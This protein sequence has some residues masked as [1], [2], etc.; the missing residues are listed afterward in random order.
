[1]TLYVSHT[2]LY[3]ADG[4]PYTGTISRL[5]GPDFAREDIVSGLPVSVQEH[6]TNGIAFDAQGRL[7]IAQ[8]GTTNAGVASNRHTR[9]ETPLS[10]AVLLAD[11]TDPSFDGAVTYLPP[12]QVT[13]AVRQISG[14]V[15]VFAAGFRN[16]YDVVAHSNGK[17]YATDNGANP[18]DGP[19]SASCAQDGGDIWAPDELN[20]IIDGGYYGHPNRNRGQSDLRQCVYRLP[21]DTSGESV[22][23]IATLAYSASANGLAEYTS[24][25]FGGLMRGDL[26]YVEWVRQRIWRVDL[27]DDGAT[28]LSI[29]QLVPGEFE[30]PL[31]VAVGPDGTVYIA[32]FLGDQ[33][34]Y[35]AP[36]ASS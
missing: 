6:G 14:D 3:V 17:V 8:G 25:S 18:G 5:T 29:S 13:E 36:V 4:F 7:Y 32:E 21:D 24:D 20:L 16:P 2:Q 15:R 9:P 27:S 33:I 23:P 19:M 31:D 22:P 26:I 10:G 34:S 1:V 35:L 28:V 12:D 30:Q 11:L